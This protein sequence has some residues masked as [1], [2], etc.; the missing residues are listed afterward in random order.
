[1]AEEVA[2]S[3]TLEL[4]LLNLGAF[5]LLHCSNI[6]SCF[7]PLPFISCCCCLT[8]SCL[9]VLDSASLD[10]IVSVSLERA[11]Q[12]KLWMGNKHTWSCIYREYLYGNV[13]WSSK[14]YQLTFCFE[15][16]QFHSHTLLTFSQKYLLA[17]AIEGLFPDC[18]INGLW[19][20][21]HP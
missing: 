12:G 5:P 13:P 14:Y 21:C 17:L 10:T 4:L 1:M 18:L 19:K 20:W 8:E 11:V 9:V 15:S 2:S 7:W 6:A 16:L 3:S